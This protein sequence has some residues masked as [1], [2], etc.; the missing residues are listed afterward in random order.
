MSGNCVRSHRRWDGLNLFI[1]QH[2]ILMFVLGV[3]AQPVIGQTLT[4]DIENGTF[5]I[6]QPLLSVT[7]QF[8]NG[9]NLSGSFIS[10]GA[11]FNN[12][13]DTM[14]G[15]WSGWSYSRVFDITT[16]G[17]TNQYAA[18]NVLGSSGAAGAGGSANYA[19]AYGFPGF[20]SIPPDPITILL[21]TGYFPLSMQVT[22]TTYAAL[23]MLNGDTFAKKFGGTSGN[24]PDFFLLTIKGLDAANQ[25]TGSIDFY[26][27]DYR[28]SDNSLDY[29]I[30][31]WTTVDLS[32]LG[33]D[34]V[35]LSFSL[36]SSDVGPFGMNT[37]A[38]FAM[39]Y[40]VVTPVPEPAC[41]LAALALVMIRRRLRTRFREA[42]NI[43]GA[44]TRI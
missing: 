7:N 16:P 18:Y 43:P 2:A 30:D 12:N 17:Y 35:A 42:L 22:N 19:V 8:E 10:A 26:L 32:S 28:F 36:S 15:V 41:W 4:V 5:P 27:A 1:A 37:P 33:P 23:S 31:R 21:P 6:G 40:L 38:Y 9:Q 13:Y 25:Q 20:G 44:T 14:F 39:D 24:D 29:I 11:I 3:C 34:T